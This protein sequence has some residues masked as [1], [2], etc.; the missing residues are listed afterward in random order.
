MPHYRQ[1]SRIRNK[2]IFTFAGDHGVVEEG[3]SAFP[4][5]VT[6][7]MVL[8]F[9]RG[10]AGVNVLARHV[11]ARVIVVDMGVDHDF[12][13]VDGLEIR[14]IGRGTKNMVKGPAMTREEAERAV[15]AGIELVEKYRDGLDLLGTGDMARGTRPL[16]GDRSGNYR[17]GPRDRDR[18]NPTTIAALKAAIIRRAI[19]EQSRPTDALDVL[20]KVGGYEIAGIAGPILG[21]ALHRIPRGGRRLISTAG[22]LIAAEIESPA[23]DILSRLTSPSRSATG[24]CLHLEQVPLLDPNLRPGEERA[25][26]RHVAR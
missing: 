8:N 16:I 20:S 9:I 22:A 18:R 13:P 3:V 21:A 26:P 2:I 24:G 23:K 25:R 1:D 17:R 4:K 7:Q 19:I 11:D 14:K 15:L 10:G 12:E 6:P 5:E